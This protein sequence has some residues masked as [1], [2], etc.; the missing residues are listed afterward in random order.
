MINVRHGIG[1]V[2]MG[3]L[4][5]LAGCVPSTGSSEDALNP[6]I[7]GGESAAVDQTGQAGQTGQA[8][9]APYPGPDSPV[10]SE[11]GGAALDS[12]YPG[13]AA[14]DQTA[15]GGMSEP[16]VGTVVDP[17]PGQ[18]AAVDGAPG[19][20]APGG[21][22]GEASPV[23]PPQG[24]LPG[25]T[26]LYRDEVLGFA[27]DYPTGFVPRSMDI[28]N[29]ASFVPSAVLQLWIMNPVMAAGDL[30]GIEPPD[31]GLNVYAAATGSMLDQWLLENRLADDQGGTIWEAATVNGRSA[32]KVCQTSMAV[33]NCSWFIPGSQYVYQLTPLTAE[34]EAIMASFRIDG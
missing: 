3:A 34:G 14:G 25:G 12:A 8:A 15:P 11:T 27:F 16:F 13:Q 33:P 2:A 24:T 30:A 26:T 23:E 28:A 6:I 7:A 17:Y 22:A 4:L 32:I 10:S 19:E 5:A 9:L 21:A 20:T 1:I 31:L 29:L 18:G